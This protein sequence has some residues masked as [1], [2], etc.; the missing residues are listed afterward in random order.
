MPNRRPNV[1]LIIT[2]QQRRDTIRCYGQEAATTPH[3][4]WLASRGARFDN[5]FCCAPM[6]SP[7][8][9]SIL[10][11]LY[12]HS[13]GVIANHQARPGPDQMHLPKNIALVADYLK[14]AGYLCGYSGKWHLGTGSD[15][16]GFSDF[17]A[18]L[19][20]YDVD[21]PEEDEMQEHARRLGIN[22]AFGDSRTVDSGADPDPAYYDQHANVGPALLP[23]ADF[24]ASLMCDKA[25]DFIRR[26]SRADAP[27]MLVFSC[28]EPHPPCVAP[29]PFH[30]MYRPEDVTLPSTW[31][32]RSFYA[33]LARRPHW[34]LKTTEEL[35]LTGD[36]LRKIWAAYLGTASYVDHLVGRLASALL[37]TDAINDTLIVFTSDHGDMLGSHG[38]FAKGPTLYDEVVRVPLIVV[39]PG[40]LNP[41]AV[42]ETLVSHADL[43]PTILDFCGVPIPPSM[44]GLSIRPQTLGAPGPPDRAVACE[45]HSSNWTDPVSPL[46]MWRTA[47]WKYVESA[48]GDHE[49]YR[50]AEDPDELHDLAADP[51]FAPVL[52]RL[53]EDLHRWC[54]ATG[55]TWPIVPLLPHSGC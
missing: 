50:L 4:D 25:V 47:E 3:V 29:R 38:L 41:S 22:I 14:P 20:V 15:R 23:L 6:C 13:H 42:C 37:E 46:R 21:S 36:D 40:G 17:A 32:D 49:L 28:T 48:L 39:P 45:Y 1:L 35:A 33:H 11:G 30:N 55:D 24:P 34:Q 53:Q 12:P 8:R 9:A 2:D 51:A 54:R 5:A 52:A 10:S 18:R 44:Q 16:R 31:Q 7:A 43:A 26:A 19:G 27:F